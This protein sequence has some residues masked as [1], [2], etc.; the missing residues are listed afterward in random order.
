MNEN[1]ELVGVRINCKASFNNLVNYFVS[2]NKY[3]SHPVSEVSEVSKFEAL[4]SFVSPSGQRFCLIITTIG[5]P[6]VYMFK[7]N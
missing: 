4:I 5:L 2:N 7:E 6:F 3:L 1:P